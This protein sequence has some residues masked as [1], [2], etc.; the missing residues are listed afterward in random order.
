MPYAVAGIIKIL[1]GISGELKD[2][3]PLPMDEYSSGAREA[4]ERALAFQRS[5]W[6]L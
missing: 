2:V 4:V 3:G 6:K 1:A 5:Y